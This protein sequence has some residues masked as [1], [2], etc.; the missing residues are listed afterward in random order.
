MPHLEGFTTT[1]PAPSGGKEGE[2]GGGLREG[3]NKFRSLVEQCWGRTSHGN[4]LF[5]LHVKYGTRFC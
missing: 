5:P 4:G 3:I 2:E 1:L